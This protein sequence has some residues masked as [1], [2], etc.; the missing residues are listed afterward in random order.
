MLG[1][2]WPVFH[3]FKGGKGA[4][5]LIGTL[6]VLGPKL[7]VGIVLVW[8]VVVVLSGFIG[9]ATMIAAASLPVYLGFFVLPAKQPLFIYSVGMAIAIVFWHRSNIQRMRE[10]AE[11]QNAKLMLFRRKA[12]TAND[13]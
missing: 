13:E 5:T 3:E 1:H 8:I 10:G 7:V 2:V 11:H 6:L 9:L 4:G 12:A